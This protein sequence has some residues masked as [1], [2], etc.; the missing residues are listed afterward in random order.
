MD[1]ADVIFIELNEFVCDVKEYSSKLF[2]EILNILL[3]Y[4]IKFKFP[5]W[6][7]GFLI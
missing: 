1:K 7:V 3:M 6:N 5:W 2:L 4:G